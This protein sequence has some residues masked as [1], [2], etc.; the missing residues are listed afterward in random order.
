MVGSRALQLLQGGRAPTCASEC[1]HCCPPVRA[2]ARSGSSCTEDADGYGPACLV[3][4]R[5]G[6]WRGGPVL[7]EPGLPRDWGLSA[8]P[9]MGHPFSQALACPP[10]YCA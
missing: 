4:G 6:G 2:A 5:V 7:Y 9:P 3:G 10:R 1:P 8:Q